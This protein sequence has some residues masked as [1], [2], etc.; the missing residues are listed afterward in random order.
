MRKA[1]LSLI[2][3][4]FS[5]FTF[6]SCGVPVT[7]ANANIPC[8][9]GLS[10]D[11]SRV[12]ADLWMQGLYNGAE[13]SG[14]DST[15]V[16]IMD[17]TCSFDMT[18]ILG[19]WDLCASGNPGEYYLLT[20]WST[21]A[22]DGCP[23]D[24]SS[25]R[26]ILL[27]YDDDGKYVL[28]S[29]SQGK[30]WEDWDAIGTTGALNWNPSFSFSG[31]WEYDYYTWEE[32]YCQLHLNVPTIDGY[33]SYSS[34]DA[35]SA[36]LIT[37]Y[38]VYFYNDCQYPPTDFSTSAWVPGPLYPIGTTNILIHE[39]E[40]PVCSSSKLL[41]SPA[42]VIDGKES[43]FVSP[44]YTQLVDFHVDIWDGYPCQCGAF[45]VPNE[46]TDN[47][48]NYAIGHIPTELSYGG[49]SGCGVEHSFTWRAF[50]GGWTSCWADPFVWNEPSDTVINSVTDN[51]PNNMTGVAVN[52]TPTVPASRHDLY[53]DDALVKTGI[54]PGE[55]YNGLDCNNSHNFQIAAQVDWSNY[56]CS[57]YWSNIVSATDECVGAPG[58]LALGANSDDALIFSADETTASWPSYTGATGYRLYRGTQA[59]LANLPG[60]AVDN[61]CFRY[62]GA[63]TS[64]DLSGDT[65]TSGSFFWYL[66]TAYNGSGEGPAGTGRI[67]NTSGGCP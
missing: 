66:V 65:P 32:Y 11:P 14:V 44:N 48:G 38:R 49:G 28:Q 4:L 36:P 27:I 3:L 40:I 56:G 7:L 2:F 54:L 24:D 6:A 30:V 45:Y 19:P 13:A 51:D 35:P 39:S 12:H 60:G 31:F 21:L 16:D 55:T 29:R 58:E 17:E 33:G 18:S 59:D 37:G 46:I 25:M 23:S 26:A 9:S 1:L 52:F 50:W 42:L 43:P 8:A 62:D 47:T 34:G 22:Y 15:G 5:A 64:I 63:S 10:S 61:S 20:D 41:I 53:V 67:I 57:T